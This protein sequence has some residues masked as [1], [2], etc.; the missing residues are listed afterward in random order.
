MTVRSADA[1][2]LRFC[3][4]LNV[5]K[6]FQDRRRGGRESESLKTDVRPTAAV[7]RSLSDQVAQKI[8]DDYIQS[9]VVPPGEL[10]PSEAELCEI[11]GVSRVTVRAALRS[12]WDHGQISVRNG[13]GA[14]VLPRAKGVRHGIDRLASI[15]TFARETAHKVETGNL[16]WKTIPADPEM[17]VK[18]QVPVNAPVIQV[19]L[20]KIFDG[21]RAAWIIDTV[22]QSIID[23]KSLRKKFNGSILDVLLSDGRLKIDYAD[24]EVKPCRS[25]G[26]LNKLLPG[27]PDGLLLFVDTTV[28][29][30]EGT[31]I[32]WGQIWLDPSSFKFSFSRRRFR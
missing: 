13:V 32:L 22:P 9:D 25:I 10:L 23:E 2:S 1:D 5:D 12:L 21:K 4:E 24:S 26:E 14:V 30:I 17:S 16:E 3:E 19:S 27:D 6:D 7:R 29:S 18:L 15:D 8:S 31:P 11:Y 28:M 20:S